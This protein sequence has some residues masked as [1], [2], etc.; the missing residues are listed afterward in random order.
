[1]D[2]YL[3]LSLA[4]PTPAVLSPFNRGF[5]MDFIFSLLVGKDINSG[6]KGFSAP[7]P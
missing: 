7:V 2:K 3:P 1:M 6:L 5:N 4:A